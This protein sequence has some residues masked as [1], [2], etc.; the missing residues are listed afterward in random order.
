MY[1]VPSG[2]IGFKKPDEID[3]WSN[4]WILL[5]RDHTL[6]VQIRETLRVDDAYDSPMWDKDEQSRRISTSLNANGLD[7]RRFR[8]LAYDQSPDYADETLVLRDAEWM[9]EVE[10]SNGNHG[11]HSRYSGG[12]NARWRMTRDQILDSIVVRP[13]LA[14]NDALRELC[15]SLD[16]AGL[17]PRLIGETLVLGLHAPK[18]PHE[19]RGTGGSIISTDSLT[20]VPPEGASAEIEEIN[21]EY[22]ESLK[23]ADGAREMT[24]ASGRGVLLRES[25]ILQNYY[26]TNLHAF[27]HTRRVKLTAFYDDEDRKLTLDALERVFQSLKL[28]DWRRS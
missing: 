22:I 21:N 10:V 27:G 15:I 6:M 28:H 20:L 4:R 19:A 2:R 18:D 25:Q 24:S 13:R 1:F 16:T 11:G 23:L 5:S 26:S 3:F 12:Q 8:M 9:G 17:N 14:I 7:L